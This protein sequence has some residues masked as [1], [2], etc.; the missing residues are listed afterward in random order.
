MTDV[1]AK[2]LRSSLVAAYHIWLERSCELAEVKSSE[3]K[4][5]FLFFCCFVLV[6]PA[7]ADATETSCQLVET[8]HGLR[9]GIFAKGKHP[10]RVNPWLYT[11]QAQKHRGVT[12]KPW[13]FMLLLF[14]QMRRI[15]CELLQPPIET[16]Q[17]NLFLLFLLQKHLFLGSL[18]QSRYYLT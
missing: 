16:C 7:G 14:L 18:H 4:W 11:M 3:F 1:S 13:E 9:V 2:S 8:E 5:F 12:V 15:N 6:F 10:P 17:S